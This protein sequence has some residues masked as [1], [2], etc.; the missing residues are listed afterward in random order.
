MVYVLP[1]Y[2][3]GTYWRHMAARQYS[4]NAQTMLRQ[5]LDNT[6]AIPLQS[7]SS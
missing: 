2:G 4:D 1:G 5:Y 3:L 6:Q 7:A